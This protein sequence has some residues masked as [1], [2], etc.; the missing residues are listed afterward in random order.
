MIAAT[1]MM[2][3][4]RHTNTGREITNDFKVSKSILDAQRI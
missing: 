3:S 4:G 2:M 1:K